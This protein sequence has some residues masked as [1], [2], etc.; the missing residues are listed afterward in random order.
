MEKS[1]LEAEGYRVEVAVDGLDAW[2]RLKSDDFDLVLSDVDMPRM[3]GLELTAR[4]RADT[5]LADL[6]VVLVTALESREDK[7]RG[8]EV[9]ANAYVVKSSFDQANVLGTIRRLI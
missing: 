5:Q 4:I 8:I 2:T 6:P 1:L 9:G 7:E 3:N